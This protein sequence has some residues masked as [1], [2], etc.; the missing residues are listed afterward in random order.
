MIWH[1]FS[2]P[3][4]GRVHL[5]HT[6]ELFINIDDVQ[7]GNIK[8]KINGQTKSDTVQMCLS[9]R[10]VCTI[11][12]SERLWIPTANVVMWVYPLKT[13]FKQY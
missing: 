13:L 7:R 6:L 8:Q 9:S 4:Y 5:M 10:H 2:L 1:K 12:L 11:K 3:I